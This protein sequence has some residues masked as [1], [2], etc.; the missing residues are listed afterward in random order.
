MPS[1]C[2]L[3]Y[4]NNLICS[5]GWKIA[6]VFV[7]LFLLWYFL[8]PKMKTKVILVIALILTIVISLSFILYSNLNKQEQKAIPTDTGIYYGPVQPGYDETLFRETG[9]YEKIEVNN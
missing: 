6:I 9:R 5:W 1:F 4:P 8:Y 7:I 2:N 3:D